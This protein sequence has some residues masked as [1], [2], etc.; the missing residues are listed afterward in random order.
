MLSV[1]WM[2]SSRLTLSRGQ[3]SDLEFTD[4]DFPER[5]IPPPYYSP[6]EDFTDRTILHWEILLTGHLIS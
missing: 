3:N 1:L 4:E 5:T 2:D 6:N